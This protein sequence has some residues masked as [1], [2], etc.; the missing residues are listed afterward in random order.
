MDGKETAMI[1]LNE[2]QRRAMERGEP[3][4][5][6]V[7]GRELVLLRTEVYRRVRAVLEVERGVIAA[8]HTRGPVTAP[9][10][11]EGL[12]TDGIP[13]VVQLPA[14]RLAEIQE[15]VTDDRERSAW[16]GAIAQA[17][18]S[19]ARDN[20]NQDDPLSEEPNATAVARQI[21]RAALERY[22]RPDGYE[23]YLVEAAW[24][25]EQMGREAW[26][27]LRD[28]L[29]AASQEC[30]YFLGTVVRLE[31]VAPQER[32]T[33]LLAA[34]RNP[35]ANVRSRLL[36]LLEE[37]PGE[38]RGEVLRELTAERRPDD[39]VTQRAREAK[40]EQAS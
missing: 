3:V 4:L 20:P 32:L 22:Q 9:A 12:P 8:G 16:H 27:V 29:L 10:P 11:L 2:D 15:L 19:W 35:D 23:G 28:L 18:E 25:L 5:A 17:Q 14:D 36:E 39:S 37:M 13:D 31:G 40:H 1:E 33:A 24:Q 6:C 7:A 30:E 34:A 21:L 26:P 38:L